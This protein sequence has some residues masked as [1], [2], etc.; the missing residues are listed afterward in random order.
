[1]TGNLFLPVCFVQADRTGHGDIEA[2]NNAGLWY[3]KIAIGKRQNFLA[4][5]QMLI[6]K[7]KRYALCEI[8]LVKRNGIGG[9]VGGIYVLILL[10]QHLETGSG[11]AVLVGHPAGP[12][13]DRPGCGN[14]RAGAGRATQ[15]LGG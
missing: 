7:N 12:A 10:L 13:A 6:A 8:Y 5:A 15:P 4:D 2:L 1:M 9:K 3:H 14:R 11:I